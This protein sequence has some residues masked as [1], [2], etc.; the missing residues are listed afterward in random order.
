MIISQHMQILST[1]T[2]V[3]NLLK[4]TNLFPITSQYKQILWLR[5]TNILKLG[6][7]SFM[8]GSENGSQSDPSCCDLNWSCLDLKLRIN[9]LNSQRE[10]RLCT[11]VVC[12]KVNYLPHSITEWMGEESG[13]L[14]LIHFLHRC[15]S[16]FRKKEMEEQDEL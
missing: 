10:G 7:T 15:L 14:C 16:Y 8:W 5:L 12:G 2:I 9:F 4:L 6:Q 13:Y 3:A 11:I 1:S